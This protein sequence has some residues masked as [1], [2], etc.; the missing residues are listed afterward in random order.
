MALCK[1]WLPHLR[2]MRTWWRRR[3][4][5]ET[6]T[7]IWTRRPLACWT[8]LSPVAKPERRSE[9]PCWKGKLSQVEGYDIVHIF[10]I[11][12]HCLKRQSPGCTGSSTLTYSRHNSNFSKFLDCGMPMFR[13]NLKHTYHQC[14]LWN[15][16]LLPLNTKGIPFQIAVFQQCI[17]FH[18]CLTYYFL[19]GV[20]K[21]AA[22]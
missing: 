18:A 3:R 7:R 5:A 16:W 2:H 20:W 22:S 15:S 6:S 12:V 11:S 8:K 10:F 14:E 4:R 17:S 1:P 21:R 13:L 9:L 19:Q